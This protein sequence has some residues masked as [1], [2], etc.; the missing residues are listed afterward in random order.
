MQKEALNREIKRFKKL[1][2]SI[3]KTISHYISRDYKR[4]WNHRAIRKFS[5]LYLYR[6]KAAQ[7]GPNWKLAGLNWSHL[8]VF[9]SEGVYINLIESDLEEKIGKNTLDDAKEN[10]KKLSH[11]EIQDLMERSFEATKLVYPDM[12]KLIY[13]SQGELV[14]KTPD[15]YSRL[16]PSL[17]QFLYD[18]MRVFAKK[19]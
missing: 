4:I 17:P 10:I 2:I 19:L 7:S 11:Q 13:E 18:A 3:E 8:G 14:L 6:L 15:F 16:H 1:T 5:K 12:T 9:E